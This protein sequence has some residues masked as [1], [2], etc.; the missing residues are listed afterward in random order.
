M[1]NAND[2]NNG[3]VYENRWLSESFVNSISFEVTG[4]FRTKPKY[5]D[6]IARNAVIEILY[7][8]LSDEML[9]EAG[10]LTDS[11][12]NFTSSFLIFLINITKIERQTKLERLGL[13]R[14]TPQR[15]Q[16]LLH[17]HL[18]RE[19]QNQHGLLLLRLQN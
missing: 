9:K 18:T 10:G 15:N 1:K 16:Y 8:S 2:S 17:V 12:V 14:K 19:F 6:I 4:V 11:V 7:F 13:K 5:N 3:E